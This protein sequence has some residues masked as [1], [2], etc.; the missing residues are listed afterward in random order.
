MNS[1]T[2]LNVAWDLFCKNDCCDLQVEKIERKEIQ[3]MPVAHNTS[4]LCFDMVCSPTICSS[5]RPG[6]MSTP[7]P[8]SPARR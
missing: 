7:G 6:G 4:T 3:S 1:V 5:C 2:D 8:R